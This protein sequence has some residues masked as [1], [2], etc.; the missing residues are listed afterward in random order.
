MLHA[1]RARALAAGGLLAQSMGASDQALELAER[2]GLQ[3][4]SLWLDRAACLLADSQMV[5]AGFCLDKVRELRPDDV[6]WE[7]EIGL[8]FLASQ[9]W[10]EALVPLSRVVELRP[11]RAF[12]WCMLA[13]AWRCLGQPQR[14]ARALEAVERINPNYPGL[15]V[16]R[17]ATWP[18]A[19]GYWL[20]RIGKALISNGKT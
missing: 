13:R 5:T 18:L 4:A 17:R 11:Q 12:A 15:Q 6:D 7:Q 2:T 8:E 3:V 19:L 9:C 16:E 20:K 14:V 1:A 10:S